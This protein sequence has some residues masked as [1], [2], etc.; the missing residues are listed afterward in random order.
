MLF[1]KGFLTVV[2]ATGTLAMGLNMPCKTVVF[3]GDSVFLTALNYRQASGRAGRRGF[4]LLGNVVFHGLHPHRVLEIMSAKLPDLRGQF[5]T[6]VTLIL[7]LFILLHGTQNSEF[8]ANAVKGLLTQSRLCLGGPDAKMSIA[9]H[10]RFSIDYLRREHLL[11]ENGVPLN[12]SGLVGHL[13]YTEN[14]VF[15]FHALLKD[16]YFHDL[17]YSNRS[18]EDIILEIML[19]L[20]HLFCRHACPQHKDKQFLERVHRSPS[21]GILPDLP[22]KASEV[23]E[24]HNQQTL[25]IFQNYVSSYANQHLTGTPDNCLP[26]TEYKVD[27]VYAQPM[28][29]LSTVLPSSDSPRPPTV[30]RSPF[31][32]LSGFTDEFHTIH[33]LCETVRAGVF[34]EESAVPYIPIA[35]KE[36]DGVP[37]N[38]YLYDFFKHGDMEALKHVNMIKGGD[39]WYHLKDF[40]L[41]LSTIVTSFAN[42]LELPNADGDFGF[43]EEDELEIA[44]DDG[45][46]LSGDEGNGMRNDVCGAP[47]PPQKEQKKNKAKKK[48][49]AESWDDES[50]DEDTEDDTKTANHGDDSWSSSASGY[51]Q[52][53][54]WA[55]NGGPSLMEI[56]RNFSALQREFEEKFHKT[57]A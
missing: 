48:V 38:A 9:H 29:D 23:L 53:P 11:S 8:A 13:S 7:R 56:F 18:R 19:V 55:D 47:A 32:A 3:T 22:Q 30:V 35:P 27:S 25:S 5:P 17:S 14:A 15:A 49:V 34:L 24:R 43:E 36:T 21:V 39:V 51:P 20:S 33:E 28:L 41:I 40:S 16:G 10:L 42:F 4:D 1:R 6:S 12:F 45:P 46:L 44:D 2:V 26:F 31:S 50:S 52:A 57:F 54:R 37:W